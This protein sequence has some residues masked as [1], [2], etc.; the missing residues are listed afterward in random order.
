MAEWNGGG[1]TES[2]GRRDNARKWKQGDYAIPGDLE[3][4]NSRPIGHSRAQICGKRVCSERSSAERSG[5]VGLREGVLSL[6]LKLR[7]CADKFSVDAST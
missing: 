7:C 3:G 6:F 2:L 1:R 5:G 4:T